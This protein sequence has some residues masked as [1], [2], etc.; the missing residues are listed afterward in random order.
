M[1]N[2]CEYFY[3]DN[4]LERK[5]DKYLD[6]LLNDLV[7]LLKKKSANDDS[8]FDAMND[9]FKVMEYRPLIIAKEMLLDPKKVN[10][11]DKKDS[12]MINISD[13]SSNSGFVFEPLC[14]GVNAIDDNK[15]LTVLAVFSSL[16][17]IKITENCGIVK[18]CQ[19]TFKEIYEE[20]MLTG[21]VYGMILNPLIEDIQI[22]PEVGSYIY[23]GC[24]DE[25]WERF[26][27]K[28]K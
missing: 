6:G 11:D 20:Y 18:I 1:K 8:V 25:E 3:D 27:K 12:A 13:E 21:E 28:Y 23:N 9:I 26:V 4:V 19:V 22:T 14:L 7:K 15:K 5:N 2:K 17:K 10:L 16:D 24:Q